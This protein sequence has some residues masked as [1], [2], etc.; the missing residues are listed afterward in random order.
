MRIRLALPDNLADERTIGAA[1]EATTVAN[2]GLAARG[3]L[4]DLFKSLERGAIKWQPERF[5]DGEHF[6]LAPEVV[7]R[8]WGDCDDLAPWLAAQLRHLGN[9][10]RATAY[11]SG[12]QR[13]HAVVELRDGKI[14]DPSQ[15]AGMP[16]PRKGRDGH[17]VSGA[18]YSPLAYSPNEA[19]ALVPHGGGW[20]ARAD[21]ILDDDKHVSSAAWDRRAIK[22]LEKA[23]AGFL[24]YKEGAQ[25][26]VVGEDSEVGSFLSDLV[27]TVVPIAAAAVPGGSLVEP[28][29]K[30]L[31]PLASS[32]LD[33]TKPGAA[34]QQVVVPPMP[35]RRY[36]EGAAPA[37]PSY[38]QNKFP[39]AYPGRGEGYVN[40]T[41]GGGPIIV[42]F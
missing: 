12:P 1:L 10:C 4:P 32:V 8:G 40:F 5:T 22:A 14:L 11:K 15:W 31:G 24:A 29:L 20:G 7:R 26:G 37:A 17:G 34:P 33:S 6:D 30:A 13:W 39:P 28:A 42:R 41:P 36:P 9:E 23:L 18:P 38:A 19:L 25:G 2:E 16:K 35:R 21:A 27:S 3:E